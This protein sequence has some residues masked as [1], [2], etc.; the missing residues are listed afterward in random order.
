MMFTCIHT[1]THTHTQRFICVHISSHKCWVVTRFPDLQSWIPSWRSAGLEGLRRLLR[2]ES[3]R[4]WYTSSQALT[5]HARG[6][7]GA[8]VAKAPMPTEGTSLLGRAADTSFDLK[9]SASSISSSS[10]RTGRQ[11]ARDLLRPLP[12]GARLHAPKEYSTTAAG[13]GV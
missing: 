1:H 8:S 5:G 7:A 4:A 10:F 2:A 11:H 3:A 12:S 9:S 6:V 13:E